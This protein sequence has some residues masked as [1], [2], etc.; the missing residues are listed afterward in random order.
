MKNIECNLPDINF[1]INVEE[2]NYEMVIKKIK[3]S[4]IPFEK[5]TEKKMAHSLKSLFNPT[6]KILL[7]GC[8][9]MK[10]VQMLSMVH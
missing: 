10:I 6:H 4:I 3:E 2:R 7:F 5:N 8:L 1:K 9:P